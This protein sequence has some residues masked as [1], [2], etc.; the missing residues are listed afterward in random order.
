M[1]FPSEVMSL[2]QQMANQNA[3]MASMMEELV[4]A[5]RNS[6]DVQQKMLRNANS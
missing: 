3:G 4:R 1:S 5:Q 2:F 6:V